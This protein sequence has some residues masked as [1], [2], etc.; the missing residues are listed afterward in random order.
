M[1]LIVFL[2]IIIMSVN[3][4]VLLPALPSDI[5]ALMNNQSRI[6]QLTD[7]FA[8]ISTLYS[9]ISKQS[10]DELEPQAL[11][12]PKVS[13]AMAGGGEPS[14][15]ENVAD[16]SVSRVPVSSDHI[17]EKMS[18]LRKLYA[19]VRA[20][21]TRI[22]ELKQSGRLSAEEGRVEHFY[23]Q[24]NQLMAESRPRYG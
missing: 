18:A 23:I 22:K 10:I 1:K 24:L 11:H 6:D 3:C 19:I 15:K 4:Q 17:D 5:T 20:Y 2:V 14:N 7:S 16:N 13:I 12:L 8:N 21:L 9:T